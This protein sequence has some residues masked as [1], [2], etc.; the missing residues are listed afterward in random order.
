[1]IKLTMI[2]LTTRNQDAIMRN[3]FTLMELLIVT[4]VIGILIA[5]LLPAIMTVRNASRRLSC[6]NNLKQIS[7]SVHQ[8]TE[9]HGMMPGTGMGRY[10]SSKFAR[11]G[12]ATDRFSIFSSILPYIEKE[13]IYSSIN[14]NLSSYRKVGGKANYTAGHNKISLFVCPS[15]P[16]QGGFLSY[17]VNTGRWSDDF[18]GIARANPR[19]GGT[20]LAEIA[21]GLSKTS[22]L[23]ERVWGR[24]FGNHK[25]NEKEIY[26]FSLFPHQ[27]DRIHNCKEIEPLKPV[28][29]NLGKLSWMISR[30]NDKYDHSR[31]INSYICFQY[32]RSDFAS[33]P[34]SSFHNVGINVAYCDGS[35]RFVSEDI[36]A[37]TWLKIGMKGQ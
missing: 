18:T 34:A 10:V 14:F 28:I 6:S 32:R 27:I 30:N 8:Y 5:L 19:G 20:K 17:A 21:K 4:S 23:S 13:G 37:T 12:V 9:T 7:I 1:M 3:G 22:M 16:G 26:P 15:Q 35:I 33:Y 36:D 31:K 24:D 29:K 11:K 25:A 2:K